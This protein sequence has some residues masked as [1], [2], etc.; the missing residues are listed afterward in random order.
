MLKVDDTPIFESAVILDYLDETAEKGRLLPEDPVERAQHRMW[1]SYI[2]N[3][4][5]K[6]WKLQASKEEET[7]R[8]LVAEL[9]GHF[10][11]LSKNLPDDGPMWGGETFTM[12][13]A[14]IAPILQ[15]FTWAETLEPTLQ[16]FEGLPK[17]K[18]WR[19]ALLARPSTTASIVADLEQRSGRMLHKYGSWVAR[20]FDGSA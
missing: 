9:R 16:L 14:A 20:G 5:S 6:G 2:S 10:E 18:A 3:I 11:E 13:D 15:R 4:I 17:I 12:V 8:A 19:D 1:I 7:V